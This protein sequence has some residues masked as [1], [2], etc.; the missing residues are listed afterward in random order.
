MGDSVAIVG[1]YE[2]PADRRAPDYTALR[3]I[4]ESARGALADSGLDKTDID[5]ICIAEET[6]AGVYVAEYLGLKPRWIDTTA[7]G[8]SSFLAHI[9]HAKDAIAAGHARA[10]L[11][12]Y[13]STARSSAAALG[14]VSRQQSSHNPMAIDDAE[15]YLLPYG[16]ILA[17]QYAMVANRHMARYGTTR[18]QLAEIAVA[19]R[20]HAGL[21]PNA[22]LRDPITIDDVMSAPPIATPLHR[23]DCCVITDG[24]G[25]VIVAEESLV[26]AARTK[27]VWVLGGAEAC[28]HNDGGAREMLDLAG[29]QS[30][31]AALA[32]A[33]VTH[34]DIDLCMI[35]DSFT[36]TVLTALE[37]LG[38]CARGEGGGFVE[39]GTLRI[40]GKLPVNPDG[41]ALS[42]H[43]PGR[44]GIF[45]AIEAARQLRGEG[46]DRQVPDAEIALC[47]GVGGYL[48]HRHSAVTLILGG[49][50]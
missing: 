34:T 12:V 11:V 5:G 39:G 10:V 8:G 22:L 23:L 36:I 35:Y 47:H 40:D 4:G 29:A 1:A 24:G 44:R 32:D 27:P 20:A 9:L 25:A 14:T 15:S 50:S 2:H 49:E 31:P 33:G 28:A 46:G 37:D 6:M 41:G 26:R 30:G 21:N 48:S 7:V 18:E 17:S 3:F 42:N 45:L 13:G 16:A 19:F 38:F 43:H